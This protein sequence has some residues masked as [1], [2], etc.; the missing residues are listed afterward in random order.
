MNKG[1]TLRL[2][3]CI[4]AFG[5][6]LYSYID[7]QNEL[8]R[9]RIHIPGMSKDLK[10]IQ[11]ENTR[12][13][14]EIDTFENPQHL[15]ELTRLGEYSHL[16]HPLAKEI[17]TCESGIAVQM[18]KEEKGMFGQPKAKPTLAMGATD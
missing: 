18:G 9:L 17:V 16:K 6:C 2:L 10:A 13:Q 14:Y 12:L 8:T 1:L 4:L 5:I 7:K 11:E 15:M 3:T